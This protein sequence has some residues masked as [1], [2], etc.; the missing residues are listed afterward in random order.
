M[1][2]KERAEK[3]VGEFVAL[4][5]N[6]HLA[7]HKQCALIALRAVADSSVIMYKD[8]YPKGFPYFS[9]SKWAKQLDEVE[10]EIQKL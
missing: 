3:L 8:I 9:E 2:A 1:T 7:F 4:S 10:H 6:A 5:P